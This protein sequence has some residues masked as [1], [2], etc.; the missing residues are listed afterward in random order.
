[1][2]GKGHEVI[3]E[4][5]LTHVL[6][7]RA[8]LRWVV[9]EKSLTSD[10]VCLSI[11]RQA[12]GTK[13][14]LKK[15]YE[16]TDSNFIGTERGTIKQRNDKRNM[17]YWA[18]ILKDESILFNDKEALDKSN[19]K[20]ERWNEVVKKQW[21]HQSWEVSPMQ[22]SAVEEYK[23]LVLHLNTS[24]LCLALLSP[25]RHLLRWPLSSITNPDCHDCIFTF[26]VIGN[27][28]PGYYEVKV[29]RSK[30]ASK[31]K[32]VCSELK[33]DDNGENVESSIPS[34]NHISADGDEENI[35]QNL[36]RNRNS[37]PFN[38][39]NSNASICSTHSLN[40]ERES[41][42]SSDSVMST[43]SPTPLK[44]DNF[45]TSKNPFVF[46]SNGVGGE[47]FGNSSG[48]C[49]LTSPPTACSSLSPAVRPI[50][51]SRTPSPGSPYHVALVDPHSHS[52]LV[53]T[54]LDPHPQRPSSPPTKDLHTFNNA[55][56]RN[57]LSPQIL[58][59]SDEGFCEEKELKQKETLKNNPTYMNTRGDSNI[60]DHSTE[61]KDPNTY[62]NFDNNTHYVNPPLQKLP[63]KDNVG[64]VVAPKPQPPSIPPRK[65]PLHEL[66]QQ[67]K[68]GKFLVKDF[69]PSVNTLKKFCQYFDVQKSS[70]LI[71]DW[72]D[73][74]ERVGLK[75]GDME[76]VND[77]SCKT[78]KCTSTEI[79]LA[80]WQCNAPDDMPFTPD[81]LV[82][83][84]KRLERYD[85]IAI[86]REE[87]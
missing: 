19:S 16:L 82:I 79:V 34:V 46:P 1:M 49:T 54:H 14:D 40:R 43:P 87:S 66:V 59:R 17:L 63:V 51:S 23:K 65:R 64:P 30:H 5:S 53:S 73:L 70:F 22:G 20:F 80:Y 41:I 77:A 29:T 10:D 55:Q 28:E 31:I 86:L 37:S 69:M 11:Y 3:I 4:G 25:P 12:H 21:K 78:G 7:S 85:L 6:E 33:Q 52:N 71:K 39:H 61:P 62:M 75:Q 42:A 81:Q 57:H 18:I 56:E 26:T 15:R 48:D 60:V 27:D 44:G 58:R 32:M 72:R 8:A 68:T 24:S 38:H 2:E 45:V 76:V 74:A 83:E 9:L 35:M 36:P 13:S 47:R 50:P 67:A 84:L